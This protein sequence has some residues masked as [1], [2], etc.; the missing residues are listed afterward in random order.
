MRKKYFFMILSLLIS[1]FIYLFYRTEHTV[2]NT[3][4]IRILSGNYTS[5]RQS[6]NHYLPLNELTIYSLPEG[7]WV[8]CITLTSQPFYVS[9]FKKRLDCVY[10]P[11][12]FCVALEIFQLF[13][14]TNGRFDFTD[15]II[16][17]VFWLIANYFF[18]HNRKKQNI[19][20]SLNREGILFFTSYAIVYLSHVF[21]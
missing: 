18:R 4:A 1:L 16:S 5:L 12:M 11:L 21:G 9:L 3:I 19:F 14:F 10:I 6:V 20:N 15:I 17:L 8:F 2:I 13:N 7:L